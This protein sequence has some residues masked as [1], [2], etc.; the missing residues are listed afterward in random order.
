MPIVSSE[1]KSKA[2][3]ISPQSSEYHITIK[4]IVQLIWNFSNLK[5]N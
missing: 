4:G 5:N 3:L 2:T 1:K